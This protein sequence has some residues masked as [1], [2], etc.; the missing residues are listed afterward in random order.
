MKRHNSC[1][2]GSFTLHCPFSET[3]KMDFHL[4]RTEMATSDRARRQ[5]LKK[6]NKTQQPTKQ[7]NTTP[8]P[9]E[10]HLRTITFLHSKHSRGQHFHSK[11]ACL[12]WLFLY[13]Y[14]HKHLHNCTVSKIRKVIFLFCRPAPRAG[15]LHCTA[16]H[17]CLPKEHKAAFFT[18]EQPT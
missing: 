5:K 14:L 18:M 8:Q 10:K 6:Q 13:L 15:L 12:P 1:F 4:N 16:A 9:K 7:N 17:M 3:Q 2:I 11:Y